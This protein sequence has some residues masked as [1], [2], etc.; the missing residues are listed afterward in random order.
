MN[1]SDSIVLRIMLTLEEALR[2]DFTESLWIGGL[3]HF[4]L[5]YDFSSTSNDLHS[6]TVVK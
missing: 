3:L 1:L 6:Q 2:L 5:G 4:V